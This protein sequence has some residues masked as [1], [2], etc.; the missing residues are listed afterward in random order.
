MSIARSGAEVIMRNLLLILAL[1][2]QAGESPRLGMNLMAPSYWSG[3]WPFVDI[4]RQAGDA[5]IVQGERERRLADAPDPRLVRGPGGWVVPQG[6]DWEGVL[7]YLLPGGNEA[8]VVRGSEDYRELP[9]GTWTLVATGRGRLRLG[10]GGFADTELVLEGGE[11]RIAVERRPGAERRPAWTR[12][13]VLASSG[14]DPVRAVQ[15]LMPGVTPEAAAVQPFSEP[16]L[17]NLRPFPA[18]YRLMDWCSVNQSEAQTWSQ[19][20][21]PEAYAWTTNAHRV[22]GGK[23]G[24]STGCVP[25]EIMCRLAEV[26][27]RPLWLCIPPLADDDYVRRMAELFRDRYPAHLPL[28]VEYANEV[29]NR[30]FRVFGYAL[31]E[32]KKAYPGLD[33]EQAR[34]RWLAR[35]H[36][37]MYAIWCQVWQADP[38]R[39][40]ALGGDRRLRLC[41]PDQIVPEWIADGHAQQVVVDQVIANYYYGIPFPKQMIQNGWLR[42]SDDR[43]MERLLAM[44]PGDLTAR[45]DGAMAETAQLRQVHPVELVCYEG[46]AHFYHI[47]WAKDVEER[48]GAITSRLKRRPEIYDTT[49]AAL[50][51]LRELGVTQAFAFTSVGANMGHRDYPSQPD[52]EAHQQRALLDWI[53]DAS[54]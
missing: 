44:I 49:L 1:V 16:F 29:F 2:V 18:G 19:R 12:L 14:A 41:L 13:D 37:Q 21:Q 35:R 26:T 39:N 54:K 45:L 24:A 22:P 40:A 3:D 33:P 8:A 42:E 6:G 30:S 47:W 32:G 51:H 46:S 4:V 7:R 43:L 38:R 36:A 23:S 17:A 34:R 48:T 28:T 27:G 31:A 11:G 50:R 9:T 25:Y 15:L 10:G 52:A 20:A 5:L 53:N